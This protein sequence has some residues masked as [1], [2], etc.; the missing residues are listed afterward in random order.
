MAS[1]KSTYEALGIDVIEH[2]N[3][4]IG[5]ILAN[6]SG[7]GPATLT[8]VPAG[9]VFTPVSQAGQPSPGLNV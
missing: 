2:P 6:S 4:E 1:L 7:H 9:L 8:I 5:E 3:N